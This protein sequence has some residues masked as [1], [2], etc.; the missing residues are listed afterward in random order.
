LMEGFRRLGNL[1][2]K[3]PASE[4]TDKALKPQSV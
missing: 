1:M 3:P 2:R 4:S